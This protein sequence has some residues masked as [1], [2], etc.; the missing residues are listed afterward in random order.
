[1]T[2]FPFAEELQREPATPIK[3]GIPA[4]LGCAALLAFLAC[5]MLLGCGMIL[6]W[7][8]GLVAGWV[9]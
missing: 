3:L 1:M 6:Y 7:S 8:A 5:G 4:T 9:S 2:D